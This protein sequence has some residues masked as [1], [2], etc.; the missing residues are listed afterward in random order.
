MNSV[1]RLSFVDSIQLS[2]I[3][4]LDML[5][6]FPSLVALV[7][8]SFGFSILWPWF[9]RLYLPLICAWDLWASLWYLQSPEAC[10]G[11]FGGDWKFYLLQYMLLFPM[12]YAI[13]KQGF[14]GNLG[15]GGRV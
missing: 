11:F 1:Y 14:P 10:V 13:L 9:W 6:S 12:Y 4:Y 8:F 5:V 7:G 15:K 3:D 2:D